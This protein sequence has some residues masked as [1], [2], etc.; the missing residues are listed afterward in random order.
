MSPHQ[1]DREARLW[2]SLCSAPGDPVVGELVAT[3]GALGLRRALSADTPTA[4]PGRLSRYLTK[5]RAHTPALPHEGHMQR[6]VDRI[7]RSG[8]Q[9]VTPFDEHWPERLNDLG[10]KAPLAL[11]FRGDAHV[12][13]RS[14]RNVAIVGTRMP[15]QTGLSAARQIAWH[16]INAGRTI[17]SGGAK[18][19]DAVGHLVSLESG[20]PTIAV[21]AQAPDR[22][23]PPEHRGMCDDIARCGV[24]VSEVPPGIHHG[25][26]GFLA[27]NRLIAA[28]ATLTIVVEAPL[29]SGAVSTAAHAAHL[30]REVMAVVYEEREAHSGS[31][32]SVVHN[33][34]SSSQPGDNRGCERIIEQWAGQPLYWPHPIG[35]K[36]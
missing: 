22:P 14:G 34:E 10:P 1:A 18:G 24:V 25:G 7:T 36:V 5:L 2:L 29:R 4:L 32:Q 15:S 9:V 6:T 8:L 16:Q 13:G 3:L 20:V 12:L 28:L 17:V 23:Y 30:E 19:I 35:E 27:R 11:F 31:T 33:G 26:K 21:L